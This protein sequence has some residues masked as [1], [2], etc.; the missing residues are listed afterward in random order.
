MEMQVEEEDQVMRTSRLRGFGW[1]TRCNFFSA[2]LDVRA[3]AIL[4]LMFEPGVSRKTIFD[5]VGFGNW[6]A[7]VVLQSVQDMGTAPTFTHGTPS[8]GKPGAGGRK[9]TRRGRVAQRRVGKGDLVF[10]SG[11]GRRE[12]NQGEYK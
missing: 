3:G 2:P 5:R 8:H 4:V 9:W 6:C 12:P 7:G 10:G 1:A 11:L